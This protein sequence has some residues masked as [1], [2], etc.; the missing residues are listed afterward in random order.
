MRLHPRLALIGAVSVLALALTPGSA[1]AHD[2]HDGH[3]GRTDLLRSGLVGSTP[4]PDGAVIFGVNPAG[5]AW[6]VDES[7]VRVRRD[8]RLNLRVEGLV[9][10]TTGLNPIATVTAS[11]YCNGVLADRT[12]PFPLSVPGGDAR[13]RGDLMLPKTCV[14]PVL[15]LNPN[16]NALAYIAADG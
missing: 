5:A 2:G 3:G 6:V 14:A 4:L 8:G 10:T 16:G 7:K 13:F 11:F 9:L 15:L 12:D 1:L